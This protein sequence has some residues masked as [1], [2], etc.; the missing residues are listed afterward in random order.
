VTNPQ[1]YY[2]NASCVPQARYAHIIPIEKACSYVNEIN[3]DHEL[4]CLSIICFLIEQNAPMSI[5]QIVIGFKQ[6]SEDKAAR[7][8]D[9][10]ILLG[11]EKLHNAKIIDKN[12][13]GFSLITSN[14]TALATKR[15]TA[16]Y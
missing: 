2:D 14:S 3:D 13:M 1:T 6:W 15:L 10:D 7:F 9:D 11:V 5:E 12:L 8:S 4:E 16:D